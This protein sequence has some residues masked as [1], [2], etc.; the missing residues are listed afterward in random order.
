MDEF[1]KEN[2]DFIP[3]Y[4]SS[5]EE[6]VLEKLS[7][8]E[9]NYAFRFNGLR[10]VLSDVHQ[11]KLSRALERLQEDRLIK[12]FP[13]GGYGLGGENYEKI[14]Q[15]FGHQDLLDSY[16]A[17][18]NS[19][20]NRITSIT[21]ESEIPVRELVSKLTGKYFGYYR[22]IGHYFNNNKGKLEWVHVED[23]SKILISSISK[24]KIEIESYNVSN[25]TIERFV[26]LIQRI[27]ISQKIFLEVQEASSVHAN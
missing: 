22:F 18:R 4:L 1:T 15:Y 7:T 14:R 11:Q 23:N 21:S 9:R 20:N 13:D 19:P 24:T 8:R 10:R 25:G 2:E 26:Q 17:I 5:L 27:L 3:Y 12:Q 6:S 16:E